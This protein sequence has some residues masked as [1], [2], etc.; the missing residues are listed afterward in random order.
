MDCLHRLCHKP[1][2]N[3]LSAASPALHQQLPCDIQSASAATVPVIP[4]SSADTTVGVCSASQG[5]QASLAT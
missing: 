1:D 2:N 3:K 4:D 5:V